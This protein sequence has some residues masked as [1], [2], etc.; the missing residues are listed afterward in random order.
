MFENQEKIL[1][2]F[3]TQTTNLVY[4]PVHDKMSTILKVFG[5]I[6]LQ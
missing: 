1:K 5:N 2:T 3:C 4:F 6:Y